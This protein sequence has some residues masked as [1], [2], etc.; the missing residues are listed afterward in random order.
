MDKVWGHFVHIWVFLAL[1]E[2]ELQCI[3]Q[4]RDGSQFYLVGK[5]HHRLAASNED[6]YRCFV[7]EKIKGHSANVG[8]PIAVGYR[9]GQSGDATCTGVTSSQDGARTMTLHR[10]EHSDIKCKFPAWL[11][12]HRWHTLNGKLSARFHHKNS[13]LHLT[14]E[15][16]K[17]SSAHQNLIGGHGFGAH[18]RGGNVNWFTGGSRIFCQNKKDHSDSHVSILARHVNG[19]KNLLKFLKKILNYDEFWV[20]LLRAN[21]KDKTVGQISVYSCHGHWEE[22]GLGFLIAT[23]QSRSS[24]AAHRYCFVYTESAEGS[25]RVYSSSESCRRNINAATESTWAFNLTS[26]GQCAEAVTA[27][28]ASGIKSCD[29]PVHN[30]IYVIVVLLISLLSN[31]LVSI[32]FFPPSSNYYNLTWEPSAKTPEKPKI[33]PPTTQANFKTFKDLTWLTLPRL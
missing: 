4:W 17:N 32:I 11:A 25:L 22:N 26:D 7:Y 24:T 29:T 19:W 28:G 16:R 3:A 23:P 13:S 33:L 2:E 31:T 15:S 14:D 6:S 27:G 20:R 1:A 30:V 18:G 9:V 21:F 5:V 12:A 10:V 8:H